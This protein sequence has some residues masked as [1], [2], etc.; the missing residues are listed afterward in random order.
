MH[1]MV[2]MNEGAYEVRYTLVIDRPELR[3]ASFRPVAPGTRTVLTWCYTSQTAAVRMFE[4]M[5]AGR[6]DFA[7]EYIAGVSVEQRRPHASRRTVRRRVERVRAETTLQRRRAMLAVGAARRGALWLAFHHVDCC[8]AAPAIIW[9][10]QREAA[11]RAALAK[12]F[13]D[14]Y[15]LAFELCDQLGNGAAAAF[16]AEHEGDD[17][18]MRALAEAMIDCGIREAA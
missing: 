13:D 8:P 17:V 5:R 12:R 15:G 11:E 18:A 10:D 7:S 4:E 16:E 3:D 9:A 14:A 1:M 6:W 2:C